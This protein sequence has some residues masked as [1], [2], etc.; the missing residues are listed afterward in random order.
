[1][2]YLLLFFVIFFS[3]ALT[4]QNCSEESL[5]QKP[6]IWKASPKGSEGGAAA[7]L[8]KEKQTIAAI[9]TMIKSKYTP[10]SVEANFHG[11]Y[12]PLYR[13]TYGNSFAYSIIP[14]NFYCDGN[15]IKTEHETGTYFS[16][17]ANIFDAEIYDTLN[18]YEATSGIGYHFIRDMPLEKDGYWQFKTI[19]AGLGMGVMGR[20]TAWLVTYSGKLPFAYVTKKEFLETRKIILANEKRQSA[21]GFQDVLDRLEIEKTYK[22]K[23]YKNDQEKLKKYMKM[24]YTDSKARYEKLLN[25]NEKAFKPAFEKIDA[26][27]KMSVAELNQPAIVKMDPN[28]HLSY[29]FTDD[30]D[31]FGQILI[32]PNPGYFNKKLPKSTPQFFWVYVRANHK[33]PIAANFM[34]DIIKAVDFSLLK[35]MLGK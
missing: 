1:M 24:D 26:Q 25:D 16:I 21:S 30:N 20:S 34:S 9:H 33:E 31:G 11:A 17:S 2:K 27:L 28:D 10:K 29:L 15:T 22:E 18:R 19:D 7:E 4:A 3:I 12:N 23:E 8:A 6:G 13:N 35:N 32:K 14:L 5:L